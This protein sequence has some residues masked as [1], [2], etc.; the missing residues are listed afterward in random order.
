[1]GRTQTLRQVWTDIAFGAPVIFDG[2]KVLRPMA[3]PCL[4]TAC[5]LVAVASVLAFMAIHA[6]RRAAW[7]RQLLIEISLTSYKKCADTL[8][9]AR[10]ILICP[11]MFLIAAI[12]HT[13]VKPIQHKVRPSKPAFSGIETAGILTLAAV[14]LMATIYRTCRPLFWIQLVD[15]GTIE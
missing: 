3:R 12:R 1:M 15:K 7:R 11:A 4:N 8:R 13:R 2:I 10:Q 5:V 6:I 14:R 9:Q